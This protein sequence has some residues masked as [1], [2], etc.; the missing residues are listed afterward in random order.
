MPLVLAAASSHLYRGARG[1][2]QG[3]VRE[4]P[5]LVEFADASAALG[6]LRAGEP[7]ILEL[8]PY[9]TARGTEIPA[10]RWRLAIAGGSFRVLSPAQSPCG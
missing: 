2:V 4:G 1:T 3:L 5:C 6:Q 8:C 10:K 7:A 9:T